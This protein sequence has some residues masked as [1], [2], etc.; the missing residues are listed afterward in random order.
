M[1]PRDLNPGPYV[2]AAST[3][4]TE[5]LPSPESR[6]LYFKLTLGVRRIR[7]S[8]VDRPGIFFSYS[9]ISMAELSSVKSK[10][11]R[12]QAHVAVGDWMGL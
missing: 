12:I 9:S 7:L 10:P 4:P 3:S 2:C 11:L 1:G 8:G 5:P 6:S